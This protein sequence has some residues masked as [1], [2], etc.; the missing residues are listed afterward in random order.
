MKIEEIEEH[1]N[2]L[3]SDS[4]DAKWHA[5][6]WFD[7]RYMVCIRELLKEVKQLRA[8]INNAKMV[9]QEESWSSDAFQRA[10]FT[11]FEKQKEW[12]EE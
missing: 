2:Q 4:E 8:L 6:I 7:A 3:Y 12:K 9:W 5:S 1:Y 11:L 10:I